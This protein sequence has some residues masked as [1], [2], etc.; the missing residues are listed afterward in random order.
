MR[1]ES[2]GAALAARTP[3]HGGKCR[4]HRDDGGCL[5]GRRPPVDERLPQLWSARVCGQNGAAAAFAPPSWLLAVGRG[6]EGGVAGGGEPTECLL[7]WGCF[8]FSRTFLLSLAQGVL[9]GSVPGLLCSFL[10]MTSRCFEVF[11][12]WLENWRCRTVG[13]G[14]RGLEG[15]ERGPLCFCLCLGLHNPD[16]CR[17]RFWG[18]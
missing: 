7:L 13:D 18:V 11:F 4:I 6:D 9:F 3:D 10:S 2:G 16:G 17:S 15:L 8:F 1:E 5:P 12:P 14:R